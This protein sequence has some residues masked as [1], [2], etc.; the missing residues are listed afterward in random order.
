VDIDIV[1]LLDW[2]MAILARPVLVDTGDPVPALDGI[3]IGGLGS[4]PPTLLQ[5]S[6]HE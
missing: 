2:W 1:I 3:S 6:L 5:A 4:T